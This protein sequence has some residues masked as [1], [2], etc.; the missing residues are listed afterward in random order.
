MITVTLTN[1]TSIITAM[2]PRNIRTKRPTL[3][4]ATALADL[5]EDITHQP[6]IIAATDTQRMNMLRAGMPNTKEE[7]IGTRL[8]WGWRSDYHSHT[9]TTIL[10][11][12]DTEAVTA[13]TATVVITLEAI[14]TVAIMT[15]AIMV[16]VMINVV[17]ITEAT[18]MEAAIDVSA[19]SDSSY[20]R[21]WLSLPRQNASIAR[22][23]C[24]GLL[25][26]S[27]SQ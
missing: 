16:E 5:R 27:I 18:R 1:L 14:V 2:R 17:I 4:R 6:V 19:T 13:A 11:E 22:L 9:P 10:K 7:I 23:S 12:V 15:V 3:I 21:N 26:P 25:T 20:N 24:A 8:C